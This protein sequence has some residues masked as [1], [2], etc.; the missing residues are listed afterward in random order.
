MRRLI[1][2]FLGLVVGA[3]FVV[4]AQG[5]TVEYAIEHLPYVLMDMGERYLAEGGSRENMP[6]YLIPEIGIGMSLTASK[7]LWMLIGGVIVG[8]I[9]PSAWRRAALIFAGFALFYFLKTDGLPPP[10]FQLPALAL[11]LLFAYVG[12]YLG[13]LL[14]GRSKPT[15]YSAG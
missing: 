10:W 2:P 14:R 11:A 15:E 1:A 6:D 5:M 8:I 3:L 12:V 13:S 4:I 9:A 7:P